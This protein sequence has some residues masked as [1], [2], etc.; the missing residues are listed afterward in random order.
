MMSPFVRKKY[1]LIRK[2]NYYGDRLLFPIW[3]V[4]MFK[5]SVSLYTNIDK[6]S[7]KEMYEYLN[8]YNNLIIEARNYVNK[9]KEITNWNLLKHSY[10]YWKI[11]VEC[12]IIKIEI[13]K[14]F[15]FKTI[16]NNTS[17]K[18][19]DISQ[20]N[21]L[22]KENISKFMKIHT[23]QNKHLLIEESLETLVTMEYINS[24]FPENIP[25]LCANI[26]VEY[27]LNDSNKISELRLKTSN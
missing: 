16:K 8:K 19:Y 24:L 15:I 5:S 17:G 23:R 7:S 1:E 21:Y 12:L 11:K 27:P 4:D 14:N 26:K 25:Y 20:I 18:I 22:V 13:Y 6:K 9:L 10:T 2:I 3:F